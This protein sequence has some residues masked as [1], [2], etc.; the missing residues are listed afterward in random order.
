MLACPLLKTECDALC[1]VRV[2]V[3]CDA[4]ARKALIGQRQD[5]EVRSALALRVRSSNCCIVP[6]PPPP[7]LFYKE[8]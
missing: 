2:T 8:M 5:A 7:P 1:S 6:P 4:A 3:G